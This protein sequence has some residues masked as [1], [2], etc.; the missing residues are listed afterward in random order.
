MVM[1][2]SS[3]VMPNVL[4][5]PEGTDHVPTSLHTG[6]FHTQLRISARSLLH[7]D[8]YCNKIRD[9]FAGMRVASRS[10]RKAEDV[11]TMTHSN[12]EKTCAHIPCGCPTEPG[13]EFCS[14]DCERARNETD[15]ACGHIDCQA[16]A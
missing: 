12:G 13:S 11:N 16:R 4:G 6:I 10:G 8:R 7:V 5:T 15:C 2:T 1:P 3:S 14:A 9:L